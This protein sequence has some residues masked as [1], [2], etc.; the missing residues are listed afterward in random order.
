MSS[1]EIVDF[2]VIMDQRRKEA[3]A[4]M[5]VINH[6]ELT[7]IFAGLFVSAEHPWTQV[8]DDFLK[9]HKG[10]SF[11]KGDVDQGDAHFIYAPDAN[12][13]IWYIAREH[14]HG[15]GRM[16]ERSLAILSE[17]VAEKRKSGELSF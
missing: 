5:Q 4:S 7:T 14:V 13:G 9:A 17:I 16:T 8:A 1:P 12:K 10:E 2:E 11:I 15:L 6:E 3:A